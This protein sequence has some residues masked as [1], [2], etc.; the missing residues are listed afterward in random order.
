L[1]LWSNPS[2]ASQARHLRPG[3]R[4]GLTTANTRLGYWTIDASWFGDPLV[5]YRAR[6]GELR[7]DIRTSIGL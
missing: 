5:K 6:Y 4:G 2:K 7:C 3:G 1:A